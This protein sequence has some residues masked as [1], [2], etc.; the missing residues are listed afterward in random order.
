MQDERAAQGGLIDKQA[1]GLRRP[2][3]KPALRRY[4]AVRALTGNGRGSGND[5]NPTPGMNMMSDLRCKTRVRRVGD[6]PAGFGLYLYQYR[7]EFHGQNRP[8]THFGVL[9][10]EVAGVFPE[11]VSRDENGWLQVDYA[12]LGIHPAEQ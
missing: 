6:H 7:S 1:A 2:Y 9:A 3:Q 8:G 11:A 5:G 10:Q 4:G 12:R